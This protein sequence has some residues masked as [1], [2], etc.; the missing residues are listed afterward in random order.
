MVYFFGIISV[1]FYSMNQSMWIVGGAIGVVLLAVVLFV[2]TGDGVPT[3]SVIP[4]IEVESVALDANGAVQAEGETPADITQSVTKKME[5]STTGQTAVIRTSMGDITVKLYGGDSPKTVENFV[6]LA[7]EGFYN[8]VKF[9]R[10]I[11]DFM[12]QTGD[13]LSKDD[14]QMGRWGMGGPGYAF[15]DEFNSHK[16]VRG[17]LAMANSGPNSNGSQFF[18]VTKDST[19]WLDGKHTNFGEVISG[20]DIV[21]KIDGTPTVP[22]DRPVTPVVITAIEVK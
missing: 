19:P 1:I 20:M 22:D 4:E 8:G 13:P 15:A 12:I 16:L 11:K 18:I 10:V 2:K 21:M 5:T 9:H 7:T 17:S 6:K 14:A 3:N